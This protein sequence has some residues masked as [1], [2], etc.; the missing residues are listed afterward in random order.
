VIFPP[1]CCLL[2]VRRSVL[3]TLLFFVAAFTASSGSRGESILTSKH[4]LSTSGP[5]TIKAEGEMEICVFC[6]TPHDS[7]P[8]APLWNRTS[9]GDTY[10][11]YNS[12]TLNAVVGQPT[13]SAKLCLSCHDGTIAL[14]LVN[15][16]PSEIPMIGGITTMPSGNTLISTDLSDDHPV[17]FVFDSALA[18]SNGQLHDPATLNGFVS[19]EDG[20]VQCT[21]CHDPHDNRYG[22]FLTVDNVGAALCLTC[23][24]K[25]F[26]PGSTH[27][28]SNA[29]WNGT[30]PD[31]WLHTDHTTVADNAC[32]NCH[33]PHS[34]GNSH[35]IL[36][37]PGEESNCFP[38]HNG[39]VAIKDLQSEF[40][41]FSAHP[42]LNTTNVHDPT[43]DLINPPRHV[44]CM[45]CHNPHAVNSSTA[46]APVASGAQA[47][48]K[49]I[50]ING[51]VVDPVAN[52]YEVCFRCHGD[53]LDRGEALIPRLFA[54]TNTR[55]E[56]EPTNASYHP[57]VAPGKNPDVPSLINPLNENS[58]IYCTDCHNNDQGPGTGGSGPRGPHGSV[59]RPILERSQVLTDGSNP[60]AS[61]Y[62]LCYKCHN[63]S[64]I[65]DDRSF[66]KH[67][68]HLMDVQAACTT[69][70]DPH[71]VAS[72]THLI[73]FNLLEVS[74][75]SNGRLEFIDDGDVEG[76]CFLT[77]HG[78]D[79]DPHDY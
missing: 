72:N 3:R 35:H 29:T 31:P 37:N 36:N 64:N 13:G 4:N 27:E 57:V 62:A 42:V 65:L 23:H 33:R 26:W 39:N 20:R 28:S 74:P 53:S 49:G 30:P 76:R 77:C 16:R 48:V 22:K 63:R 24:D 10:A 68:L 52:L 17:S 15:S 21:S 66:D 6:H 18:T 2:P 34:A 25:A 40:S 8:E 69:C 44:E 38:C 79:H 55:L 12:T 14:G 51:G 67:E 7:L 32:E 60:S 54:Q 73:N 5:G 50:T 71:G 9:S 78:E 1:T 70:H 46:S 41:K 56:F 58:M 75:S 43:E 11:P 59:Y 45:D 61:N 19:L 47:G